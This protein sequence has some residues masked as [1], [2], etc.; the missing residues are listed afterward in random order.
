[1]H[2]D[3]VISLV[4]DLRDAVFLNKLGNNIQDLFCPLAH[5]VTDLKIRLS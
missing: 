4:V 2:C 5:A 1:M 3:D